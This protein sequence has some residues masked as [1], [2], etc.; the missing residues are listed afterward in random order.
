MTITERIR[1]LAPALVA[2]ALA[3]CGDDAGTPRIVAYPEIFRIEL[4]SPAVEGSLLRVEGVD[5]DLTGPDPE[6]VLVATDGAEARLTEA[7]GRENNV[8]YFM[9]DDADVDALGTGA[10]TLDASIRGNGQ[11]SAPFS[12]VMTLAATLPVTLTAAPNG[13]VHWNDAAPLEGTGIIAASEGTLLARFVGEYVREGTTTPVPVSEMRP[14][15]QAERFSRSRGVV[16]LATVL[17]GIHPGTFTGT[18]QLVSTLRNGAMSMSEPVATT[19]RFGLPTFISFDPHEAS[20]G[21]YVNLHGAGFLGGAEADEFTLIELE[22]M[23]TPEGGTARPFPATEFFPEWISGNHVRFELE[24]EVSSMNEL[25]QREFGARRGVF[26]GMATAIVG[27]GGEEVR[28]MTVPFM[29][30]L[31]PVRQVVAIQYLP[32]FYSSLTRFGLELA[33]EDIELAVIARMEEIYAEYNVDFRRELADDFS[34][35]GHSVLEIGGPDPSGRGL[36]GYDNT[37]GKDIGNLRLFDRIGGANAE[38]QPDG[39]PGYGGVFIESFL[40]WSEHPDLP[41]VLP[42]GPEPDP[43]FDEIFDP[44]REEPATLDEIIGEPTAEPARVAAVRRA[45]D[46]LASIIGETSSHELGH[47]LGLAQPYGSRMAFH[48]DADEDGCLMDSGGNRPFGERSKQPGFARTR[49][50]YDEPDY[51]EEILGR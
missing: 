37:P 6:L 11:T 27:K 47:S 44:V 5:L 39:A 25:I 41:G 34:A 13:D 40:L 18:V 45:I 22:G 12:I 31:G 48:N 42:A 30:T 28:G 43:L 35:N 24:A 9:L 26:T 3:A 50:C 23:F 38:M 2:F 32:G 7:P 15:T 16:R 14:V 36:F 29:F 21:Q 17:G 33:S 4:P 10:T 20:I 46:A 19:L 51:L 49:F 8:R 1:L